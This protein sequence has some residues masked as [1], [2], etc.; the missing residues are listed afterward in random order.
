MYV[1]I[2]IYIYIYIHIWHR[3]I[4]EFLQNCHLRNYSSALAGKL[5]KTIEVLSSD[6]IL[7]IHQY[8]S[9]IR[10]K[11]NINYIKLNNTI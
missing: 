2:Y 1:Y 8:I 7:L 10:I 3:K 5:Q 4:A 6:N 9:S 11:Y